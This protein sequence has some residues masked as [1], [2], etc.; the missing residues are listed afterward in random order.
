M[1]ALKRITE[2]KYLVGKSTDNLEELYN[3]PKFAYI[4]DAINNLFAT[5]ISHSISAWSF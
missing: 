5:K 4:K 1:C 3:E 2:D